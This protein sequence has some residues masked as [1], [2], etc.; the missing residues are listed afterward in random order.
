MKS[1]MT[2][3]AVAVSLLFAA[4]TVA[5]EMGVEG[6]VA[7]KAAVLELLFRKAKKALVNAAQDKNFSRY[8]SVIPADEKSRIK[9]RID[10]ISL[11]VQSRFHVEEMCLIN[12]EGAEISHI[13]GNR[14]DGINTRRRCSS[15]KLSSS[16]VVRARLPKPV[17]IP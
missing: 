12:V 11:S 1:F 5:A 7:K 4:P 2:T 3:L 8:F 15:P 9:E 14:I 10:L 6:T 16:M 17:L 13:V